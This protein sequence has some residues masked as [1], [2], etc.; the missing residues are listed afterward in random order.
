MAAGGGDGGDGEQRGRGKSGK[1]RAT[2]RGHSSSL[3]QAAVASHRYF[4]TNPPTSPWLTSWFTH[5]SC[6]L[7]ALL[8]C[9]A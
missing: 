4:M 3:P 5:D 9:A 8:L 1:L 6:V 2:D 7:K